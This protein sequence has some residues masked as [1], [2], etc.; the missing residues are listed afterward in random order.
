[1]F[2]S[3]CLLLNGNLLV[4]IWQSSL[5]V[6]LGADQAAMALKH[7]HV[8]EFD[9]TDRPMKGWIMVE[10]DGLESEQQLAEWIKAAT[11]FV[12]RLPGK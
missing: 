8:R 6:R 9:V 11:R 2:G 12:E 1:M 5:I 3:L 10:P 4:G 7:D